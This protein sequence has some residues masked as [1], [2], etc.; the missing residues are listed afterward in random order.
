MLAQLEA[1]ARARG[2]TACTLM[3][4]GTAR[5]FYLSA[6]YV[7]QGVQQSRFGAHAAYRMTKPLV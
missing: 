6:G 1:T 5:R 7:D 4:T 3:S 2:A